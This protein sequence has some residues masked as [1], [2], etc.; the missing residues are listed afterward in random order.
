MANKGSNAR[1]PLLPI[2][3]VNGYDPQ[4]ELKKI[5]DGTASRV[6]V[7]G[8]VSDVSNI[9]DTVADGHRVIKIF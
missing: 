9:G 4:E 6:V 1:G 3:L 2:I 8:S 7:V 5:F